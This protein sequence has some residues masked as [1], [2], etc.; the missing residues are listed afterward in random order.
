[1]L[2]KMS[3]KIKKDYEDAIREKVTQDLGEVKEEME[4]NM[5][6]KLGLLERKQKESAANIQSHSKTMIEIQ[7]MIDKKTEKSDNAK[8]KH[9]VE[10]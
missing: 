10:E 7:D 1:M 4:I 2:L 6:N 5:A 3:L 8:L 9:S